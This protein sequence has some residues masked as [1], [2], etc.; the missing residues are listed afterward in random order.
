MIR[1]VHFGLNGIRGVIAIESVA[2]DRR[3]GVAFVSA[4]M[5]VILDAS[6][7]LKNSEIVR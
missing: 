7:L 6:A 2:V 1:D 4:E 3:I 5:R